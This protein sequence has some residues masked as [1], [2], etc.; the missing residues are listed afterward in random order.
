MTLTLLADST[1]GAFFSWVKSGL[2]YVFLYDPNQSMMFNTGLFLGI[3]LVFMALYIPMSSRK[4]M[5]VVYVTLFSLFFYY[6]ASGVYFLLL[7]FSTLVDYIFGL[8]I[9]LH[10]AERTPYKTIRLR[11]GKEISVINLDH[12]FDIPGE[13]GSKPTWDQRISAGV[14]RIGLFFLPLFELLI[15]GLDKAL[16]R[17]IPWHQRTRRRRALLTLSVTTNLGLLAYFK[18]TDF[19][20]ETFNAFLESP[21]ASA[22]IFLPVGISF[23]TFQTMSYTIDIYRGRL[24]P[25][26]NLMDFGFY[27]SFFPQ[28]VAGPI[29]RASDFIPQI[30]ADLHVSK[31]DISRA[32]LLIGGGMVKKLIIADFIASNLVDGI[33]ANPGLYPG[34]VNLM[35]VYGYALQIYCDFSGYTDIAIGIGL[36]MGFRLPINFRTP[37]RSTSVQEFWRRWHIS[38]SSWLRDYLYISLGGNRKGKIRTYI[39][40][41]LTM[42]LGGL[43]HGAAW[44][45]IFWGALHGVALAVHRMLK[46][47]RKF[48]KR[49]FATWLDAF[50]ERALAAAESDTKDS[51]A[52]K[53][54]EWRW[55]TQ[56]WL[57]LLL[58]VFSHLSG[59]F[60]TFHFV[61]ITWIFFRATSFAQAWE[62]I[63]QI[64]NN[65]G[66]AAFG[67]FMG[68]YWQVMIMMG[69]GY[70]LHFLPDNLEV[71]LEKRFLHAPI[72]VK[73]FALAVVLTIAI[74][75]QFENAGATRFIYFQF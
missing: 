46:D 17:V 53:I 12:W 50:D 25:V 26:S 14:S 19:F 28:L 68:E 42:F 62:M 72:P 47:T 7:I 8:L 30:R 16:N 20:I 37:Y 36:L 59:L 40:L 69:F 57:P 44:T 38:L 18:Y 3:F 13:L 33:F 56:S 73:S 75:I 39:N 1:L 2:S 9:Y 22:D 6:K 66:G 71:N 51:A 41:L 74:I 61:C 32:L 54:S 5:R 23:F 4:T 45:F 24:E 11:N 21:M 55:R 35:A 65:F 63:G 52:T 15:T 64:M 10:H 48:V 31:E 27:V 67:Q 49:Q 60:F 70:L 34:V 43:W 58:T 29:V